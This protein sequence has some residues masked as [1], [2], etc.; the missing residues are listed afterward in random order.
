MLS[1]KKRLYLRNNVSQRYKIMQAK[2]ENIKVLTSEIARTLGWSY[3]T[4]HSIRERKSPKDRYE[5]Y[6]NCEKK[7]RKAKEEISK[8]LTQN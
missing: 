3:T 4:A 2:K 7:L 6:L 8:E 5:I 1:E